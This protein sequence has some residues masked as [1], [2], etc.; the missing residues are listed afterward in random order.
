LCRRTISR[1]RPAC[2]R[3]R[4]A[5]IPCSRCPELSVAPVAWTWSVICALQQGFRKDLWQI[6][7]TDCGYYWGIVRR[8]GTRFCFA[9]SHRV[10][11][12]GPTTPDS[13]TTSFP[14]HIACSSNR[15]HSFDTGCFLVLS[16]VDSEDLQ[17]ID[18]SFSERYPLSKGIR[19]TY[20]FDYS[21][22]HGDRRC[23]YSVHSFS[24]SRAVPNRT[25]RLAQV[26]VSVGT[27]VSFLV[28]ERIPSRFSISPLLVATHFRRLGSLTY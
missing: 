14:R 24:P 7:I 2:R 11:L 27:F 13:I 26:I 19:Y 12:I 28:A 9:L 5:C 23:P 3:P 17:A 15:G 16:T 22:L 20:F 21:L 6:L 1:T 10:L 4:R 25:F 8:L 18:L